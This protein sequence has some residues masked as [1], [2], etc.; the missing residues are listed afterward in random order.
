[1]STFRNLKAKFSA[2]KG[3]VRE[4]TLRGQEFVVTPAVIL[5]EGVLQGMTAETPEL[6]L[7]EEFGKLPQSWNGRPVTIQ[8]PIRDNTPSSANDPDMWESVVV[9]M[10]FNT[11]LENKKLISEIW[12]NKSWMSDS[13]SDILASLSDGETLEVSTGLFVDLEMQPGI[14]NGEKYGAVW[15]NAVPDHLA[16]LPK[17]TVGACSIEDGCGTARNNERIQQ[18]HALSSSTDNADTTDQISKGCCMADKD[19]NKGPGFLSRLLTMVSS[20]PGSIQSGRAKGDNL[21][22]NVAGL[23]MGDTYKAVEQALSATVKDYY[24]I[25]AVYDDRVV[26]EGYDKT[27]DGNMSWGMFQRAYSI[28]DGAIMISSEVLTVRPVTDFVPTTIVVNVDAEPAPIPTTPTIDLE[29]NQG[30]AVDAG[31]SGEPSTDPVVV[32][33]TETTLATEATSASVVT[34]SV[35]DELGVNEAAELRQIRDNLRAEY[36]GVIKSNTANGFADEELDAMTLNQLGKL[37]QLAKNTVV[38][39]KET[40][41]AP[42]DYTVQGGPLKMQREADSNFVA[43]V[44]AFPRNK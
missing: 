20:L 44:L 3:S 10:L 40:I 7:A 38:Q 1:M 8:H 31:A 28:N 43:P 5:V 27:A 36:I 42:V 12:A 22:A 34:P 25:V 32:G 6:A 24:Y 39:V 14:W 15:H 21:S 18:I 19:G 26:Y 29:A 4:E 37:A 13:Y 30:E 17:G 16:I 35:T 41:S 9:G 2:Q 33:T 11:R 23:S